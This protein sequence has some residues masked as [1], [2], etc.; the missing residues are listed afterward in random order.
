MRGETAYPRWARPSAYG[1]PG[2]GKNPKPVQN[3]RFF[4]PG[5]VKRGRPTVKLAASDPDVSMGQ[6][7]GCGALKAN[8][9]GEAMR[10]PVVLTV[11]SLAAVLLL[12]GVA[13]AASIRCDGGPCRGTRHADQMS[14]SPRVD[15]MSGLGSQDRMNGNRGNDV[16]NGG[17]GSDLMNGGFG[18]DRMSGGPGNDTMTGGPASDNLVGGTGTDRIEG[19]GGNDRIN[20]AGDNQADSVNCGTGND[21][22]IF[23]AQ[24][25]NGIQLIEFLTRTNCE[26]PHPIP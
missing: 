19:D 22:L 17:D 23:D 7:R 10:R 3:G 11:M 25:Q 1:A 14:G 9:W 26:N 4:S 8:K 21:T 12:A 5:T 18:N 2:S 6:C 24:D 16:M 20:I 15:K 13:L